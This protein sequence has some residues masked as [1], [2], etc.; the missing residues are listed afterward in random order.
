M[1]LR[2]AS[3]ILLAHIPETQ[4]PDLAAEGNLPIDAKSDKVKNLLADVDANDCCGCWGW[5]PSSASWLP[6]K[7]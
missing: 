3:P 6:C 4:S 5:N 7:G 1:K 2:N